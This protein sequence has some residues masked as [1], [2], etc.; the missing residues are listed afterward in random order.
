MVKI[1]AAVYFQFPYF[2]IMAPAEQAFLN[3]II[4][5]RFLT[6]KYLNA[7]ISKET[8]GL[9]DVITFSR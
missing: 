9:F 5:S 3:T 1:V 2:R 4:K 8:I 7:N 6:I